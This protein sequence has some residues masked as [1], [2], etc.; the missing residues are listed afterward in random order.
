MR[1]RDHSIIVRL[2]GSELHHLKQQVERTG[3]SREVYLRKLIMNREIRERPQRD[4]VELLQETRRQ[5]KLVNAIAHDALGQGFVSERQIE[6]LL[7]G[8]CEL[9]AT[10]KQLV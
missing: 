3:L 10:A 9:L 4:C 7:D 6:R 8:Y 1:K 5:G 2:N